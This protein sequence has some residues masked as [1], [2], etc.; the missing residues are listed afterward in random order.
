MR[1]SLIEIGSKYGQ[2]RSESFANHPLANFIRKELES[3][4]K[5]ALCD[6]ATGLLFDA[7]CGN[8]NWAY[9][10]WVAIFDPMVTKSATEGYYVV[11]LFSEKNAEIHLSINQGTTSV[12]QEHGSFGREVLKS[13][14][15]LMRTRLSD[16]S[17]YF[18]DHRINLGYKSRLPINYEHGHVIGRTYKIS[19][20]PSEE[21]LVD[22]L[23]E[24][25]K[26]YLTLTFRD[27]SVALIEEELEER[28]LLRDL[29]ILEKK[30]Y[31]MHRRM[32][33]HPRASYEVKKHH[34]TICQGCNFDF[35]DKYGELGSGYIEAHHLRPLSTLEEGVISK[36]SVATDFAVLC[37][38]CHRMIHRLPDTS[39]INGLRSRILM[40]SQLKI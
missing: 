22:D 24:I 34:G 15:A 26:A 31:R 27:D 10:P 36:Y 28:S 30:Q 14:A 33:R 18:R 2:A 6:K 25:V 21:V 23:H 5:K 11:Y 16:F 29:T 3:E 13:R 8:G 32:D 35:K 9:V 19:S 39:D 1:D 20:F 17:N 40:A 37:A 12:I 38:N 4:L 7:S